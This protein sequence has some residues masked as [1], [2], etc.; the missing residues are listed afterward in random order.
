MPKDKQFLIT[1]N[2]PSLRRAHTY[3]LSDSK[4]TVIDDTD[5]E[6][7]WVVSHTEGF[8]GSD[9]KAAEIAE[10]GE[11]TG[12]LD[13]GDKKAAEGAGPAKASTAEAEIPDMEAFLTDNLMEA[14]E[15]DEATL[16]PAEVQPYPGALSLCTAFFPG[17]RTVL[18]CAGHGNIC[19]VLF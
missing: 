19:L 18:S 6:G 12:G 14:N 10:M 5:G 13:D 8:A 9:A 7:G 4:D 3:I 16:K 2:V 11:I 15:E 17:G 1:R